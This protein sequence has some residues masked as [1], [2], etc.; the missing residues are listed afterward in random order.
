MEDLSE[1][2]DAPRHYIYEDLCRDCKEW[3]EFITTKQ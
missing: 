2:C 1:C 3:T